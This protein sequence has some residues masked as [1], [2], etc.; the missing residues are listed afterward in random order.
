MNNEKFRSGMLAPI[1]RSMA[2][3]A[4]IDHDHACQ[5]K[6]CGQAVLTM[7]IDMIRPIIVHIDSAHL[8]GLIMLARDPESNELLRAGLSLMEKLGAGG[9]ELAETRR[10]TLREF[11]LI[12]ELKML[13]TDRSSAGDPPACN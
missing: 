2:E 4:K 9:A 12:G 10:R 8:D 1:M 5:C 7:M 6:T 3:L 11:Q 13:V